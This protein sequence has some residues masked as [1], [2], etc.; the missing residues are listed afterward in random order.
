LNRCCHIPNS[1]GISVDHRLR[2][3]D[4]LGIPS[5]EDPMVVAVLSQGKVTLEEAQALAT[6]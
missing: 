5:D 6:G 1:P 4:P 2:L 3:Q